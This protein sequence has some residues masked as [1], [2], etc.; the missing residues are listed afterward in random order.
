MFP[1]QVL[2]SAL[3]LMYPAESSIKLAKDV[4]QNVI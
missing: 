4:F 3:K 1:L 2:I